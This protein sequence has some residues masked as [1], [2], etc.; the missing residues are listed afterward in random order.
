MNC[1]HWRSES[2]SLSRWLRI[3]T[4]HQ[5]RLNGARRTKLENKVVALEIFRTEVCVQNLMSDQK[6]FKSESF[7]IRR[8][9]VEKFSANVLV[10]RS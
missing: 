3:H 7:Q 1:R 5:K 4:G 8:H 10:E 9:F 6:V 2:D